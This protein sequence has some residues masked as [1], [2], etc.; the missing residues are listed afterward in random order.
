[1][2]SSNGLVHQNPNTR[3]LNVVTNWI[4]TLQNVAI[5]LGSA[6][7]SES[8][9]PKRLEVN[10]ERTLCRN[11]RPCP[12]LELTEKRSEGRFAE[13]CHEHHKGGYNG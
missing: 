6:S 7:G 11:A 9:A 12:I 3:T 10:Y 5:R 4:M 13:F 8:S 2:V 1:M